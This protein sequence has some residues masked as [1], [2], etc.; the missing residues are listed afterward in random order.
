MRCLAPHERSATAADRS[1]RCPLPPT[2]DQPELARS[3][4]GGSF[5]AREDV[6]WR[7]AYA[8]E[9]RKAKSPAGFLQA[10]E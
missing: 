3:A 10:A 1:E 8:A 5:I 2:V 6:D 7:D 4:R 9:M